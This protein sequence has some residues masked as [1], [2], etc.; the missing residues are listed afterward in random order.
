MKGLTFGDVR[1]LC[2]RIDRV[3]ICRQEDLRYENFRRI[4]EVPHAYDGYHLIGFGMIESEFE[5]EGKAVLL[6]CLEFRLSKKMT[7]ARWLQGGGDGGELLHRGYPFWTSE[8][9]EI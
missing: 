7:R 4:S 3:S 8:R 1:A 6:P 9:P 5:A 2:S